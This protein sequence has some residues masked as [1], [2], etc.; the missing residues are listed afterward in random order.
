[1]SALPLRDDRLAMHRARP[2]AD[3]AHH[4]RLRL[5][6]L[7]RLEE[8]MVPQV[9]LDEQH[10]MVAEIRTVLQERGLLA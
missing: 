10:R 4:L 7:A 5:N 9:I 1:M 3:L 2:T 8:Q 6:Q